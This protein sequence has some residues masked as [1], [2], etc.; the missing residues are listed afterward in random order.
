MASRF[1]LGARKRISI[2]R[3]VIA[4][5]SS[6]A[7]RASLRELPLDA[8]I[9]RLSIRATCCSETLRPSD[10][11]VD[12]IRKIQL[13]PASLT[14][15]LSARPPTML[16]LASGGQSGPA[17]GSRGGGSLPITSG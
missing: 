14:V 1:G 8:A 7:P 15:H 10:Q 6:T 2:T 17:A 16:P 4:T 3:S 9:D 12:A 5:M 11:L 13:K